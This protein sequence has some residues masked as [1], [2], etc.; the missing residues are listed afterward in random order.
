MFSVKLAQTYFAMLRNA[1]GLWAKLNRPDSV[2]I[3][4]G[5]AVHIVACGPTAL[6]CK[7]DEPL[8][9]RWPSVESLRWAVP[10]ASRQGV[11]HPPGH[12][13]VTAGPTGCG[14]HAS[15]GAGDQEGR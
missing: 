3:A 5:V 9:N 10:G 14:N 6:L 11:A 13:S 15:K 8:V 12:T 7:Y 4:K 1:F 2:P